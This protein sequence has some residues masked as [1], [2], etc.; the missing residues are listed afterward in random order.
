M[1][2]LIDEPATWDG[3]LFRD[4]HYT[5]RDVFFPLHLQADDNTAVR[6]AVRD[7][8]T[9]ADPKRGPVTLTVHHPDGRTRTIDGYLSAPFGQALV[10]G[11]AMSWR[12]AS[13]LTLRCPDPFLTGEA[14]IG[15]LF[16]STASVDFLRDPFLPL[17][18]SDSQVSA[19]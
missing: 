15:H 6:T 2:L 19:P 16:V 13:G 9:L 1:R 11:E 3:G 12:Q 7:L 17:A 8:A 5:P 4:A 14:S 18:V 10:A